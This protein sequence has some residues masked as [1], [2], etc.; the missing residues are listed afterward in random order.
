MGASGLELTKTLQQEQGIPVILLTA[1]SDEVDRLVGLE[2]G[3][4]DYVVKPFSPREVVARVRAVLRRAGRSA[5]GS[6][7]IV[8]GGLAVDVAGR[9]VSVDGKPV[10]LTKTEF[11]LLT[12]L[13]S[14][15]GRVFTRI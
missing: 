5:P 11:D 10:E 14:S 13:A 1:K 6:D 4:D 8:S 15:P 3:A 2:I 9:E 7:R 12:T